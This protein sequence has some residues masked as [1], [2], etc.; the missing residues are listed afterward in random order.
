MKGAVL[1]TGGAGYIGSHTT[2]ALA[3]AG[4][5]PVVFDNLASGHREAARW[6]ELVEGDVRDRDALVEAMRRHQVVGVIHFAGLIEVG[7]SVRRPDLFYDHNVGGTAAVLSAMAA[8][9]VSR[10]V[11]SSSAAVYGDVAAAGA[12]I[13]EDAPKAP[14]SPYG[15]TKLIGDRK[16][17]V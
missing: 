9:E 5:R 15:E 2:K 10:L 4:W 6:G 1:V 8:C 16:S 3:E 13:A 14:A 7:R 12:A 17:V 11:F